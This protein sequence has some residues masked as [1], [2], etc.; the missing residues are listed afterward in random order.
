LA[1]GAAA[2]VGDGSGVGVGVGVGVASWDDTEVLGTPKATRA[3]SNRETSRRTAPVEF[4]QAFM[5]VFL[6]KLR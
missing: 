1:R 2:G 4:A 6:T 5:R 3:P